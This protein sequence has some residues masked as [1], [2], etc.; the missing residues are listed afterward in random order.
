MRFRFRLAKRPFCVRVCG[1]KTIKILNIINTSAEIIR[2]SGMSSSCPKNLIKTIRR[3]SRTIIH[4][5]DSELYETVV[6]RAVKF[7]VV[8]CSVPVYYNM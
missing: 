7:T 5:C 8:F 2:I 1:L 4:K 6:V 3:H